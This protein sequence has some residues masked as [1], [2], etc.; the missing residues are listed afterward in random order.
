M[1]GRSHWCTKEENRLTYSGIGYPDESL[2]WQS[3]DNSE[4]LTVVLLILKRLRQTKIFLIQ[5]IVL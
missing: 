1:C 5:S 3:K 4:Y 2:E